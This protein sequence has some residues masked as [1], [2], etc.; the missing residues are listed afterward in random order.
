MLGFFTASIKYSWSSLIFLSVAFIVLIASHPIA[1]SMLMPNISGKVFQPKT[2][3]RLSGYS[4]P[5]IK[6]G[7]P[8]L[9]PSERPCHDIIIPLLAKRI[10]S[11]YKIENIYDE[12]SLSLI[13]E[14]ITSK[15]IDNFIEAVRKFDEIFYSAEVN[16]IGEEIEEKVGRTLDSLVNV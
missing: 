7:L 13:T 12:E 10:A 14:D 4:N 2:P 9:F 15:G 3:L 6:V 16:Q 8:I 5:C 1:P 11:K